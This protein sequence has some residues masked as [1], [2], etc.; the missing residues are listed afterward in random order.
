MS[1]RSGLLWRVQMNLAGRFTN[2]EMRSIIIEPGGKHSLSWLLRATVAAVLFQRPRR[3]IVVESASAKT[4]TRPAASRTSV[5]HLSH[6]MGEGHS[7]GG[8]ASSGDF[9]PAGACKQLGSGFYRD[10]SPTGFS[11]SVLPSLHCPAVLIAIPHPPAAPGA[12]SGP[13]PRKILPRS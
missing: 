3:G 7:P 10:F 12:G 8:A 4:L 13:P 6:P 9:A 5:W 1:R 2:G 11:F